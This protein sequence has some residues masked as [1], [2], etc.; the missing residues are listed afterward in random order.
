MAVYKDKYSTKDGRCWRY[1]SYFH[2][3]NGELRVKN[4]RRY[5][6]QKEALQQERIFLLNRDKPVNKIF[7]DV[8][9]DYFNDLKVRVRES[10]Y[11]LYLSRYTHHIKPIFQDSYLNKITVL[12]IERWKKFIISKVKN[13]DAANQYYAV[14]Y[15]IF[16]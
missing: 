9:N 16:K 1:K 10:T 14:F 8:A 13:T 3:Y 15:E 6:T 4:S 12:D 5:K 7:G 2:N 11:I